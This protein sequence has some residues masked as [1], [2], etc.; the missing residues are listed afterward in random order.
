ME[1][2][3]LFRLDGKV[4][5]VTG[6]SSGLGLMIAE[7]FVRSGARVY[8]CGRKAAPLEA[9]ADRLSRY[10]ECIALPVDISSEDD[11][12]RLVSAI[13]E[14]ESRL[15]ILVN[16]A[17][18]SWAAP[19]D[20][21]PVKGFEKVLALNVTA[22]FFLIQGLLPY[23]RASA[24]EAGP[25]RIINVGSIDRLSPPG[26]E[27]YS[28]SASKAGLLMMTRHLAK[29]LAPEHISVNAI[30]PG[31]FETNMTEFIFDASHP[32]HEPMP[33]LTLGNRAGRAEDIAGA[34]VYLASRAG[35]HL[36]RII[37]PV[38]GGQPAA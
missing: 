29:R 7:G 18:T 30:A 27:A 10:G 22:P 4:A 34:A 14:R 33:Q 28:Y 19:L 8:I 32:L 12:T 25:A 3:G 31:L 37:L 38:S 2:E 21:F 17:G 35:S 24:S 26:R 9:A 23:L 16:N 20:Q 11:R 6:A 36:T 15:H 5:L 13:A 1:F